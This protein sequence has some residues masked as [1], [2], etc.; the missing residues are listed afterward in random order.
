MAERVID[1]VVVNND[2]IP[3][4]YLERYRLAG[5]EE[6]IISQI[7]HNYHVFSHPLLSFDK[8]IIRHDANKV[9]DSFKDIMKVI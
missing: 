8:G 5:S 4:E 3:L 2:Q 1:A 7:D 9:R 6:V